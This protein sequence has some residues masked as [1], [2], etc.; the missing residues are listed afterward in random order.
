MESTIPADDVVNSL[1]LNVFKTGLDQVR[2]RW[3]CNQH[4]ANVFIRY[5]SVTQGS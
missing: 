5:D 3:K 1:S 4:S 2:G